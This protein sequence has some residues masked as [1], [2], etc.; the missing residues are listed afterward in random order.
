MYSWIELEQELKQS[1]QSKAGS[2]ETGGPTPT[3]GYTSTY[4]WGSREGL[5]RSLGCS[6]DQSKD[7]QTAEAENRDVVFGR[8]EDGL[9]HLFHA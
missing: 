1:T 2:I 7:L 9:A 8:S 5:S 6:A 3:K 4:F